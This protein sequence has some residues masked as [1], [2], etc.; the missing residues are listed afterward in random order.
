[1]LISQVQKNSQKPGRRRFS[2]DRDLYAPVSDHELEEEN[3]PASQPYHVSAAR[4]AAGRRARMTTGSVS[5]VIRGTHSTR[6]ESARRAS[7]SGL[8]PNVSRAA[9]GRH[10][11]SG[12]P[13]RENDDL[14]NECS[15]AV[16]N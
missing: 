7:T 16:L 13:I 5:A 11:P 2:S 9:D 3:K 1:M 8:K 12:T 4:S 10:I 6:E 14:S 15:E